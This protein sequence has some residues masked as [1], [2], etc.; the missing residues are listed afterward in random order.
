MDYGVD[1][2]FRETCPGM[3]YQHCVD[4]TFITELDTAEC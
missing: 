1:G 4:A 2:G 3:T